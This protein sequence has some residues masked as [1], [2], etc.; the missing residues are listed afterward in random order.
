MT[1]I[2]EVEAR[3]TLV[4]DKL[5][6][7][8]FVRCLSMKQLGIVMDYHFPDKAPWNVT[9]N[10]ALTKCIENMGKRKRVIE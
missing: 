7:C 6:S 1:D 5:E 2:D 8:Q 4:K 10:L 3:I 9:E